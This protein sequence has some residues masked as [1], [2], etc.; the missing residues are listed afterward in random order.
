MKHTIS[1]G[2]LGSY[3]YYHLFP[4]EIISTSR[5]PFSLTH[6]VTPGHRQSGD[7]RLSGKKNDFSNTGE[8]GVTE[9]V[10]SKSYSKSTSYPVR[11]HHLDSKDPPDLDTLS[12]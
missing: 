8:A 1:R 12:R 3:I 9:N 6:K 11:L 5:Q 4:I 2:A 7:K 10:S